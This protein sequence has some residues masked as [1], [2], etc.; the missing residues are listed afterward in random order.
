[1]DNCGRY[2]TADEERLERTRLAG[3]YTQMADEFSAEGNFA[4]ELLYRSMATRQLSL[5]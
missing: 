2:M 1:M 4:K 3:V 5:V